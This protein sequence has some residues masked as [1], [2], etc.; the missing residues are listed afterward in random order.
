MSLEHNKMMIT[1]VRLLPLVLVVALAWPAAEAPAAASPPPDPVQCSSGSGTADCTVSSAYGVFPDRSTCRAAAAVYPS[2]EEELVRAVANATA[3][4]TKM[5]V[6]TRYSHSI[7][8]LACPGD[9]DGEG[10]VISTRRLNRVVAVDAGRMEVTVESGI[11]LRELIAEAGKA[12]MALPYAPYWW[13]LTV[14][15]MLGTGAHGSSLWGK[16]SAVHEYVVGMRIVTPAPAADGYAKVRVLTAAD[17][18]LDAA[19]VSLGVLGVISQVTLALQPL[20]KRSVTFMERD[21]DDLADQVT[22]FGYQH[23]FAD[24]AWYPGIGRAV[25]RVDDRLP[26]N[27]SGEGVLDFIGFRATPRLLIRTNRLAE[28]LFERAGNGNGKCVTSRVT[29]AA[30]SSAGYGLMRRSGGLFTGY[31]VV[32]PQHLMQASGG[33]ITGPEDALLTACPWDPRVRG[34][35]FFHQTTFSLPVSRA[36]AFVEEVRRL[37]DMNPKALCGVELYDGILIRYVKASTA[38]L[39]KPAAGGGQS[40]DM[41]DFDMTYYRSRDPNRARLF[42]DVLEEIEQMGVFKYGGLPHW[43]KNRNLAFVGAARKYPRIGEF[44]RIKDAYDPDGLFS[45]DW[46]DMMLGI[47][48]RAPTRDAPGCALEGMCVC[49]QDAHCAPEQ[50][51]VCR[52]G[53]V[54]K[55]ARVCTKV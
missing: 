53:K 4:G 20:F 22:K 42:E 6:A 26:M 5:K 46:S 51:Y 44:L 1:L 2:T 25:Y 27:A 12:G 8:Q 55:D 3:S 10:L 29:H 47:G 9:G 13:G 36:G 30:L 41:V 15:G 24:I 54:Y 31:P 45:S 49:S 32:G 19:K 40:D 35:S 16:G 23:E 50:G 37:R 34:S 28:E 17:P 14:G 21:D 48:G 38:H 7:P 18:E 11:S 39:G 43:G 33:C 52:P